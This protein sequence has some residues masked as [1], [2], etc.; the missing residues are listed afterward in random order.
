MYVKGVPCCLRGKKL[1]LDF[2]LGHF[3]LLPLYT[4]PVWPSL[5]SHHFCAEKNIH[6]AYDSIVSLC[7]S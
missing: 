2:T 6:T 1:R 5:V 4:C 3:R 7:D